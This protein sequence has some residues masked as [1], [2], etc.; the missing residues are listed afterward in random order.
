MSHRDADP[1]VEECAYAI[2]NV[3]SFLH[4]EL[5]EA[6]ADEIRGHLMMCEHC[7]DL[8]DTESLITVIVKR[9]AGH[10]SASV[11]LRERISLLHVS[12]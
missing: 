7:L 3:Q 9:S 4:G 12:L 1:T 2:D 6:T 10:P 8:Y 11:G 5:D